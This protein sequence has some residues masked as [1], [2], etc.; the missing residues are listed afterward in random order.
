MSERQERAR[1]RRLAVGVAPG[2]IPQSPAASAYLVRNPQAVER[3]RG[4]ADV[5]PPERAFRAE[6]VARL[7]RHFAAHGYRA[8]D[9]PV[10]EA[11]ELFLRKSGEERAA[12]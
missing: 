12:Q 5:L 8:I 2:A 9:T 11:T 6:I 10:V 7:E 3:V 4:M 1:S